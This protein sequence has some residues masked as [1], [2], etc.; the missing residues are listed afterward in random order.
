MKN[1]LQN[2]L[3]VSV[4]ALSPIHSI[5]IVVCVLIIADLVTG[6]WA[7][8]KRNEPISSAALRRTISKMVIYQIAVISAFI[9]QK[10]LLADIIPAVNLVAGVIGMV[11][12][13]SVLENASKILG[14]DLFKLVIAK[15]GS[16]NDEK[17]KELVKNIEEKKTKNEPQP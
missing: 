1:W 11:E 9:V 8:V 15:L 13:K 3:I 14:T 12:L 17:V 6:I 10:W 16:D 2:L 7:A 5:M 4:A